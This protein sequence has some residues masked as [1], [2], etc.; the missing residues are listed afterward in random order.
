MT[1]VVLMRLSE[2][3]EAASHVRLRFRP[4]E[5]R[6]IRRLELRHGR[7]ELDNR[8]RHISYCLIVLHVP[9]HTDAK[10]AWSSAVICLLY[11]L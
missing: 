3:S 11:N 6:I 10:Y 4:I 5:D 8:L 7:S 2:R 1:L 9:T